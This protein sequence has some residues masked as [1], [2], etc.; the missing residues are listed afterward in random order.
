MK[1]FF[2]T[3]FLVSLGLLTGCN[4]SSGENSS[5]GTDPQIPATV[6]LS[7]ENSSGVAQQSFSAD[8]E[9]YVIA[10]LY[11]GS[12]KII[13]GRTINFNASIGALSVASKLTNSDGQAIVQISNEELAAGAGTV[14]A[15]I[16]EISNSADFEF[17]TT[18]A[19]TAPTLSSQLL[20]AGVATS[21][22][23]ANEQ[24]QIVATLVDNDNQPIAGEIINF[25]ADIGTLSTATALSD[26]NGIAT[27][28]LSGDSQTGAGVIVISVNEKPSIQAS[29]INY[30]VIP[31][32]SVIVDEGVRIGHFD[33][34]GSFVEGK[35]F[36]GNT[37]I[38]AGGTV[39]ITVNLVNGSGQ[40]I[41]TPTAVTFTSNCVQSGSAIIDESVLSIRGTAKATFEDVSCA[42]AN[43]TDDVLVASITVNGITS[44]ASETISIS[45]ESLGSIEFISA[46]PTS[47][48]LKGTG[49]QGK[50][51]TSTLTFLVKSALGNPLAQQQVDFVLDTTA[52]GI[53]LNPASGI[54]NSQGLITTKVTAGTVPTAV[55]VTAKSSMEVD[56]DTIDVQTQSDLLS[57]NT[58]LPEQSSMTIATSLHNPEAFS[59]NGVTADISAY[60]A[61]NFN[62][63]VPDGTTVNFTTEGGAIQGSCTTTNG[64]CSV[65]W[66]SANPRPESDHRITIL[67]TASGHESFFESN[68]NNI[69]DDEDGSAVTNSDVS[70]GWSRVSPMPSGFIDMSEAWR[71]DNENSSYDAG[72]RFV[73]FNNDGE[74]SGADGLFNGPQCQGSL[75]AA[76]GAN[77]IHVR[78]SLIMVMASSSAL[79]ELSRGGTVYADNS[80]GININLP[81]I[82]DGAS[83]ALTLNVTDTAFQTMPQGTTISVSSS[84]GALDGTTSYTVGNT[85]SA[86]ASLSFV[87]TNTAGGDPES[88]VLTIEITAPSGTTTS[89]VKEVVLD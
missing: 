18:A 16:E 55:R 36:V 17:I 4:G 84:V 25:T 8:E 13:T 19:T 52:G 28:T 79:Y 65:V 9:A 41:A 63:P 3:L 29:R 11:D 75:C 20:L 27:V 77:E 24:A 58:G 83:L 26:S 42:G 86:P 14:T 7:I 74:F 69:F 81:D 40:A 70:A 6:S 23:K 2:T 35:V 10:T 67:A 30:E 62:N 49:G 57:I 45:G 34:S 51:E 76:E 78:K 89:I 39:G 53:S 88:G 80:E 5:P 1:K 32:D 60:L 50:Q 21:Q 82:A 73:D 22:I 71:D 68:G 44:I 87:I 56:G 54:T 59:I 85:L 33:Q 61:D 66:T 43:G 15:T 64:S 12:N 48:V 46:E 72:E 47:I 31:T 38:S 37:N